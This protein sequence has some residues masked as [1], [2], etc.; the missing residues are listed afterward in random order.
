MVGLSPRQRKH[1][2][3][4]DC[5]QGNIPQQRVIQRSPVSART[6]MRAER[7]REHAADHR[8]AKRE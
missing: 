2:D 6:G 7:D 3:E 4:G 5:Q 1:R 8:Y